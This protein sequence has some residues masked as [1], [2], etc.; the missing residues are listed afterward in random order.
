MFLQKS[1]LLMAVSFSTLGLFSRMRI[2]LLLILSLLAGCQSL[3]SPSDSTAIEH[4][5]GD[6]ATS[7]HIQ[8]ALLAEF[9]MQRGELRNA[10]EYYVNLAKETRDA[11]S[12]EKATTIAVAMKKPG[13]I[14]QTS[15]LWFDIDPLNPSVY[16]VRFS[17][18]IHTDRIEKA[19][20]VLIEA[21]KNNQSFR[22]LSDVIS[23][24]SRNP[25]YTQNMT[26]SLQDLP[27]SI[28]NNTDVRTALARLHFLEGN[29]TLARQQAERLIN[30]NPE[31][32]LDANVFLILAFSQ[33]RDDD[34]LG[35]ISTLKKGLLKLPQNF[36]L[37]SPL[38]EFQIKKGHFEEAEQ[39]YQNAHLN[40]LY[41]TQLTINY[42]SLLINYQ[43]PE[44]ALSELAKIDY[45]DTGLPDQFHFLEANALAETGQKDKAIEHLLKITHL[46]KNSA[47]EQLVVWLYD[48]G[49]ETEINP[50]ILSRINTS[51]EA[52]LILSVMQ[53]HEQKDALELANN[54]AEG[55]L[56]RYP[57][58]DAIRYKQA[59]ILDSLDQWQKTE[60]L[61]KMLL[62]KDPEN[63]DYLNALG[64]T[65]LV[66]S[67]RK[68]EAI[69]YIEAAYEQ[70][71]DNPAIIDSLGWAHFIKGELDQAIYF[72]ENAWI[73][74][75]DPEIGAHYGESL[76]Q[77][78]QPDKAIE[79]WKEALKIDRNHSTLVD[80][81]RRLHPTL[82]DKET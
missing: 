8:K 61:L 62:S 48:L 26:L 11:S 15:D 50:T 5:T 60:T 70:A 22:F 27:H 14:D 17:N 41:S 10:L 57:E 28:M 4:V 74:L 69:E 7:S 73:L 29:F 49:R 82:L 54:L 33:D 31:A 19:T 21:E 80:T 20:L 58:A 24:D 36:S 42:I 53:F 9:S 44:R 68:Q 30:D 40:N 66:R 6:H 18:F 55:F 65:L 3:Y 52:E 79:I 67:E 59:L 64:Y 34:T 51:R 13:L 16:P 32:K 63:P 77:Q 23:S 25:L 81:L 39:T 71:S 46:L 76:W 72:L 35:A 45:E 43:Q 1:S 12:A 75:P 37:L 38:I 47:T 2:G 56:V 78:N